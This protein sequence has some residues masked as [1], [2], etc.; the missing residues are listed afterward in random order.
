M[1]KIIHIKGFNF[2]ILPKYSIIR[3]PT[4]ANYTV[5]LNDS[6]KYNLD[7]GDQVDWN[8]LSGFTNN[9]FGSAIKSQTVM[10]AWRYYED[11]FQFGLYLHDYPNKNRILPEDIEVIYTTQKY[12]TTIKL[13]MDDI[14]QL[15]VFFDDKE[16][17][18]P[19]QIKLNKYV[20]YVNSYFGGNR[21]TP[22]NM[23]YH[24]YYNFRTYSLVLP[25]IKNFIENRKRYQQIQMLKA[26]KE[27]EAYFGVDLS[28][29]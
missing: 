25:I 27:I 18:V 21:L 16:Y 10:I 3:R 28:K 19:Y 29:Y 15:S 12:D 6:C 22:Q 2:S 11:S 13:L 23:H 9:L 17:D 26:R 1:K 5:I 20:R 14:G 8:K 4:E 24:L 7:N